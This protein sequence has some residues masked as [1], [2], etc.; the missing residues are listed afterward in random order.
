MQIVSIRE[1]VEWKEAMVSKKYSEKGN[2]LGDQENALEKFN[3]CP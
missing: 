2:K 3:G 1:I